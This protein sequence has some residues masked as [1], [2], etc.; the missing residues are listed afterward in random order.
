MRKQLDITVGK[1]T[2]SLILYTADGDTHS[3]Y[4]DREQKFDEL[5]AEL[6]EAVRHQLQ[7]EESYS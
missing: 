5:L 3:Y 7:R 6:R 4:S 1:R 2:L